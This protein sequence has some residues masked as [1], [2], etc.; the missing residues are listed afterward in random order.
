MLG[1]DE[2]W[3]EAEKIPI[4]PPAGLRLVDAIRANFNIGDQAMVWGRYLEAGRRLAAAAH[5]AETHGYVRLCD[6]TMATQL[7]VDWLTG[8]WETISDRA[9]RL[10]GNDDLAPGTQLEVVLVAGQLAAAT[11]RQ[12]LAERHLRRLLHGWREAGVVQ[13]FPEASA[14]LARMRLDAGDGDEALRL[15]EEALEVVTT[16]RMWIWG[17]DIVPTAVRALVMADRVDEAEMLVTTF[18]RGARGRHAPVLTAAITLSRAHLA[19]AHGRAAHAADL[20]SRTAAAWQALPRPYDAFLAQERQAACLLAVDDHERAVELLAHIRDG[21]TRLGAV[22][23]I[24]RVSA[25]LRE[26]GVRSRV[27][28]WR[29]GSRGYGDRLSPREAEVVRLVIAGHTNRQVAHVLSRSPHTVN[30][31]LRSAMGKL[32]VSSRAALAVRVIESGVLTERQGAE[33]LPSP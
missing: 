7:H 33:P 15:T 10:I 6:L 20:Y 32:G 16:K 5:L 26:H 4:D 9:D 1:E 21:F 23:D 19:E 24:A 11:G 12:A 25:L 17:T 13:L 2:G 8:A 18:A 3:S 29:G 14:L 27:G 28:P 30:T 31:Q 22:V